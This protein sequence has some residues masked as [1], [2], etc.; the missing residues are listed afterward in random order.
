VNG[1]NAKEKPKGDGVYWHV[2]RWHEGPWHELLGSI[3]YR[4]VI[5]HKVSVVTGLLV[6]LVSWNLPSSDAASLV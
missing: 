6:D 2:G 3:K 4:V 1:Q 5:Q